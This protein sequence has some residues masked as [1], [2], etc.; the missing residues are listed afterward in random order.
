MID[1]SF[2]KSADFQTMK[3]LAMSGIDGCVF[4]DGDNISQHSDMLLQEGFRINSNIIC[5]GSSK[6]SNGISSFL[7]REF[8]AA[9]NQLFNQ[10]NL[11]KKSLYEEKNGCELIVDEC[12]FP[13]L[14]SEF[15]A[16]EFVINKNSKTISWS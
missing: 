15:I 1:I 8:T 2:F 6:L 13:L 7:C 4:K 11:I 3:K 5:W 14:K 9:H 12:L 16:E 10:I